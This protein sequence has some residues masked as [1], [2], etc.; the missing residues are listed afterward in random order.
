MNLAEEPFALIKSGQ[1]DIEMRLCSKGRENIKLPEAHFD[2]YDF[3]RLTPL[4]TERLQAFPDD[5]TKFGE[6]GEEISDTQRY[7]CTGNAVTTS[8]ITY[9]INEMFDDG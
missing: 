9:I 7:R 4:E 8:V 6:N 2:G 5:W 1:K 3:R